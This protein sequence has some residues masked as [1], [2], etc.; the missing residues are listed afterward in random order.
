MATKPLRNSICTTSSLLFD[1]PTPFPPADCVFGRTVETP[2]KD[3]SADNRIAHLLI[4]RLATESLVPSHSMKACS[5][6]PFEE[7]RSRQHDQRWAAVPLFHCP[8]FFVFVKSAPAVITVIA[9]YPA[10]ATLETNAPAIPQH[11]DHAATPHSSGGFGEP[12]LNAWRCIESQR[13]AG[14]NSFL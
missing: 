2:C 8:S 5:S 3:T 14:N 1:T 4:F 12:L 10:A 13:L 9:S 6:C 11:R 7:A